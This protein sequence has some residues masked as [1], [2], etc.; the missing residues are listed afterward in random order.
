MG[1]KPL[2]SKRFGG[3]SHFYGNPG[4][5]KQNK[6]TY[7]RCTDICYFDCKMYV[8]WYEN[9]EYLY[10]HPLYTFLALYRLLRSGISAVQFISQ[11]DLLGSITV[12]R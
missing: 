5:W 12:H 10:E 3:T 7:W 8:S 11:G 1:G 9:M 2:L 4:S 6:Q